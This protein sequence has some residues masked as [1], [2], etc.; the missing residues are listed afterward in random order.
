MKPIFML[1]NQAVLHL[2][3]RKTEKVAV[4]ACFLIGML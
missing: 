3:M 2:S 1:T 4:I